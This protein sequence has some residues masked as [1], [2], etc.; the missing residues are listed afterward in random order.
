MNCN[1]ILDIASGIKTF[2]PLSTN[3]QYN[4]T[5]F[6]I[7]MQKLINTSKLI[8]DQKENLLLKKDF[9]RYLQSIQIHT[10]VH[11]DVSQVEEAYNYGY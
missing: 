9:Q 3:P 8:S 2:S 6:C 11:S 1:V 10:G 4:P 7:K 5:S